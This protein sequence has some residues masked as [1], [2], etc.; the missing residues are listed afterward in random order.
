MPRNIGD[1]GYPVALHLRD[2]DREWVFPMD[3]TDVW[4]TVLSQAMAIDAGDDPPNLFFG[5][6]TGQIWASAD[7]GHSWKCIAQHLPHVYAV[8]VAMTATRT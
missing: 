3:G 6:T 4:L 7:A 1:I 2:P 5:S 8:E